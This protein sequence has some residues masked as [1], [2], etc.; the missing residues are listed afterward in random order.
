MEP[1]ALSVIRANSGGELPNALG[2]ATHVLGSSCDHMSSVDFAFSRDLFAAAVICVLGSNPDATTDNLLDF[3]LDPSITDPRQV[4]S[5]IATFYAPQ[6]R[7]WHN[8][9]A[10]R[11]QAL[12]INE[13]KALVNLCYQHWSACLC[14]R[15]QYEPLDTCDG[16]IAIFDP[17]VV[18][19]AQGKLGHLREEKKTA[20]SQFLD[21]ALTNKGRRELPNAHAA[22]QGLEA[23]KR[24][25]ENLVDPISYMQTELILNG[26]MRSADF[27]ISPILLLGEPG[28]GKTYLATQLAQVIGSSTHKVSAGSSQ[29]GFQLSGSH[30]SWEGAKHGSILEALAEGRSASPV[31]VIDEVDKIVDGRYPMIPV[32]L[33]LL[34]PESA[35]AFKD[36]YFEMTFD[37]S[38]IIFVLTANTLEGVPEPL[39][40]RVEVFNVPRPEMEQRLRVIQQTANSLQKRLVNPIGLDDASCYQLAEDDGIDMRKL[41]RVVQESFGRSILNN[42]PMVRL[43]P[44]K[45][46]ISTR[47]S[48]GFG[49]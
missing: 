46:S 34:E 8:R 39:L 42:E 13:A 22:W 30:T 45:K 31:F 12:G 16:G 25:F 35:K 20:A 41:I 7:V 32:L 33:D 28:I 23:A 4:F 37:A 6:M 48:I 26:A 18:T 11:V 36:E 5:H 3:L 9:F 40:S 10:K 21:Q 17:I 43:Q 47:R 14:S 38:R 19:Q 24:N 27:H 29:G 44:P 1:I 15:S 2:L 49:L